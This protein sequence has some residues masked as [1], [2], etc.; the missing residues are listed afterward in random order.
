MPRSGGHQDWQSSSIGATNLTGSRVADGT[1]QIILDDLGCTGS[2]LRLVDCRHRGLG[3]H[4]CAHSKDA[5]VRCS[6]TNYYNNNT[7]TITFLDIVM[8][9]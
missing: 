8:M 5:G 6:G 1:G 4:N 2:E 9:I 7:Y 3:I